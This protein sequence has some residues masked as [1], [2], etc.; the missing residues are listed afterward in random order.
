MSPHSSSERRDPRYSFRPGIA[1]VEFSIPD[2]GSCRADLTVLS[3]CG[4]CF[5]WQEPAHEIEPETLLTDVTIHV[6]ECELQ[7]NVAVKISRRIDKSK[8][9]I[10]GLFYPAS[11]EIEDKLMTLIAGIEAVQEP[12]T[13]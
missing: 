7:G 13:G 9:E 8:T 6:G 11:D 2:I 5:E 10:G 1:F 3:M 4:L 12:L